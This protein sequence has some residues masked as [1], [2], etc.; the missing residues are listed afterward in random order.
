MKKSR[1]AV[2]Q[3]LYAGELQAAWIVFLSYVVTGELKFA[4]SKNLADV[5]SK[6]ILYYCHERILNKMQGGR[7]K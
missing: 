7:G 3:K 4:T 1:N 6:M 2:L 5:V